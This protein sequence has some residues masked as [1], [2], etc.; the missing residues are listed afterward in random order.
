MSRI[1]EASKSAPTYPT[2]DEFLW[3]V[4]EVWQKEFGWVN[5]SFYELWPGGR[6]IR[7]DKLIYQ[8]RAL[9]VEENEGR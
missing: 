6:C 2:F 8:V 5:G 7:W 4:R 9:E 3:H 1:F